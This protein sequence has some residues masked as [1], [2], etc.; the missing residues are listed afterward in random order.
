[1]RIGLT[2]DLQTD[3]TDQR[4]LEFDAPETIHA[5][6]QALEHWGHQVS[7][8][9]NAGDVLRAPARLRE[10]DVVFNIA[11]GIEGRCREAWVPTLLE[12]FQIPYVGSDPL[13]LV[14]G[15]DKV[16]SKRVAVAEGIATPHWIA[17]SHPQA[18]PHPIPLPF[19]L[20]VKPRYEGSGRG[21][22]AGAIVHTREQLVA[23]AAWLL[24]QCQQPLVIEEFIAYGELTVCVIG[25]D[26]PIA[27][28]VIQR[29]IDS[30]T[31]LS[32]HVLKPTPAQGLS[33]LV[34]NESLETQARQIALRMF[35]AIGC[36]DVARIDLRVDEKGQ[37]YFLEINPLP[38]FDPHGSFGLLAESLGLRYED[39][40]GRVLDAAF[41]RLTLPHGARH[42][43]YDPSMRPQARAPEP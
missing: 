17:I 24:T 18:L 12:L 32:C 40:V 27:Y 41:T 16:M 28:P 11:E 9:G 29:P 15:L 34:L 38:S 35:G 14:M 22:D 30:A 33:P 1:M 26:L 31:R 19:P 4:Q 20:I 8:L 23:R 39:L 7:L 10:V 5:L 25:N 21:I 36:R 37:S 2:Y 6:R 3:P 13:A 42:P 43:S